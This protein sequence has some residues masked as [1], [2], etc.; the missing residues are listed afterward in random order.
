M[1]RLHVVTAITNP[2]RYKS[3]PA[4][5]REFVKHIAANPH[6]T[7]WT[8]EAAFGERPFEVTE[9]GN[10][11]HLQL[12]TRVEIW[13][14]ENLLNLLIEKIL[15]E[16]DA[17]YIAWVDADVHFARN[18]WAEETIE[19]LQHYDVVQMFSECRDLDS[20]YNPVPDSFMNS[21][22]Y[23]WLHGKAP[24]KSQL[25]PYTRSAGHCGYAWAIRRDALEKIGG[26]L[27]DFAIV[28][29][30]DYQMACA[31]MGKASETLVA[32]AHSRY[33]ERILEWEEKARELHRN[34]GYVPGLL[35]HNWHGRK[36]SR[37]YVWRNKILVEHQ[38]NPD[39]D[40]GY[41]EQGLIKLNMD[42]SDRKI[43]LRDALRH[44]FRSRNEDE[45]S[46]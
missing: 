15:R 28:G 7:L 12:R 25:S 37:G 21:M 42:G 32:G 33:N 17:Q 45:L 1:S 6:A 23:C 41:D 38:F 9:E 22:T 46:A 29:S 36:S 44:Y 20:Q 8:A 16:T 5:Y 11:N 10:P 40:I 39:K 19:Q 34:V 43:L 27:I 18:D 14:K 26:K 4:L 35:L 24:V 13:H 31:L 30:A 3:R 2:V